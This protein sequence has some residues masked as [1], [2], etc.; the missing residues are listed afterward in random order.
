MSEQL[1][2]KV[3]G[4][5]SPELQTS[6]INRTLAKIAYGPRERHEIMT[7]ALQNKQIVT[8][9]AD[10][11]CLFYVARNSIGPNGSTIH[12]ETWTPGYVY[13][14]EDNS[15]KAQKEA[16]YLIE[17]GFRNMF[18]IPPAQLAKQIAQYQDAQL[19]G[20]TVDVQVTAPEQFVYNPDTGLIAPPPVL[21]V[22]RQYGNPTRQ[23][24]GYDTA[25]N[26]FMKQASLDI[27]QLCQTGDVSHAT[28]VTDFSF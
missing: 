5:N 28:T 8:P 3:E 26:P 4:L 20:Q 25:G 17:I 15:A 6:Y 19:L 21:M 10:T 7:G 11:S 14:P 18:D 22:M 1:K 13:L 24:L 23:I 16:L 9:T 27:E 12:Y 2:P